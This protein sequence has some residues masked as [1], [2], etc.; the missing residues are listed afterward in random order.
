M[1]YELMNHVDECILRGIHASVNC[2]HFY[3]WHRAVFPAD[4]SASIVAPVPFH[5]Q[6][7]DGLAWCQRSECTRD[8]F[9]S[10][11]EE[12]LGAKLPL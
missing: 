7:R 6:V 3:P 12:R 9:Y 11:I 1:I 8:E 4:P 10:L 2:S 5:V